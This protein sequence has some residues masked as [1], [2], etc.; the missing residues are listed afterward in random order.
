MLLLFSRGVQ[1]KPCSVSLVYQALAG[2]KRERE[3]T[4]LICLKELCHEIGAQ[5][6]STEQIL[7]RLRKRHLKSKVALLQSLSR[8]FHFVQLKCCQIFLDLNS[9]KIYQGSGNE[10]ESLSRVSTSST[11]EREIR[12]SRKC[13]EMYKKAWCT[14]KVVV[15]PI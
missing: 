1:C 3:Q 12:H 2:L 11:A 10:K 13:K 5:A 6:T 9:K 14:C 7:W 8:I 4:L 15:L